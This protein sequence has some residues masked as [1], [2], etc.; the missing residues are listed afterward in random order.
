MRARRLGLV[1]ALAATVI[2]C[3]I[4]FAPGDFGGGDAGPVPPAPVADAG[5]DQHAPDE[6]GSGPRT[7]HVLV[8]AGE[9][10]GADPPASDV[11]VFAV[12]PD[13]TA[14]AFSSLPQAYFRGPAAA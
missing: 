4:T 1:V 6:A 11:W 9:R 2:G 8:L 5:L 7:K 3:A 13:G 12:T 10:D 14:G